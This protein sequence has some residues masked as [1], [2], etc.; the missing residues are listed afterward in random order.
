[1]I[2][3][4]NQNLKY[5]VANSSDE[6]WGLY[7]TTI[8]FQS[9]QPNAKYPPKTHPSSY[10]FSPD[11]GRR[12]NEYQFIYI[13][14]GEG[15]FESSSC[16]PIQVEAGS[17]ILVFPDEWHTY[18]PLK[19]KGWDEYWVGCKG[20][21]IENLVQN[22]FIT[23]YDPII[24]IG[25]NEQIVGLFK[26]GMEIAT[27][28]KTAY[29]QILAGIISHLFSLVYYIQKNNAFRDKEAIQLIEKARVIM[30]EHPEG[31]GSPQVIAKK[32]NI[33]YSWFRRI[34][35]HYTG[36]SP[37]QYMLE[38]KIQKSKELLNSTTMSIKEIAFTLNFLNVSY[39]VTF[40]K[41]KTGIRP[42]EYRKQAH[43]IK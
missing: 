22:Q 14:S 39:F 18:K 36:L 21:V 42:S 17:I 6:L 32:L 15:I 9:I 27:Y 28:Q 30:R 1:M 43:C 10:W 26:H 31:Y 11:T 33:S 41:S 16:K 7:I 37:A 34:F 5:L 24:K 19:D 35:K 12:L 8:G 40:F 13:T 23:K 4:K 38:I 25:L 20:G 2:E 3:D 29:Q